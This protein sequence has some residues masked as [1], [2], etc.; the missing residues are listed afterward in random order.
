MSTRL[1][2]PWFMLCALLCLPTLCAVQVTEA[3][4]L[5][6]PVRAK[7]FAFSPDERFL[8][9][10][11]AFGTINLNRLDDFTF[12]RQLPGHN[13]GVFALSFSADG[14]LLA[15]LGTDLVDPLAGK[16]ETTV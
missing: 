12:L 10:D 3:W 7:I 14:T 15:S 13:G 4:R 16:I 11:G 2:I 9:R 6:S 8:A 5:P 1:R